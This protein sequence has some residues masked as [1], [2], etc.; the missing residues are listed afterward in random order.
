MLRRKHDPSIRGH[1]DLR[2]D[3]LRKVQSQA[4]VFLGSCVVRLLP[5]DE[6]GNMTLPRLEKI[7]KMSSQLVEAVWF[8]SLLR[9]ACSR[10]DSLLCYGSTSGQAFAG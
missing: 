9:I 10:H 6:C 7:R 4:K 3:C 1:A 5:S 2:L 8:S